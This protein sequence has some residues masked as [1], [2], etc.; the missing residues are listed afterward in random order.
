MNQCKINHSERKRG[1]KYN[2][3]TKECVRA[4][5]QKQEEQSTPVIPALEKTPSLKPELAIRQEATS[6]TKN[7]S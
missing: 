4:E 3:F 1:N 7:K 5:K 6:K 2:Q